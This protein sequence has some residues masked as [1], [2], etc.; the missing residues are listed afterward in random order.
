MN[1][2]DLSHR[3]RKAYFAG[4]H[5][6]RT[7]SETL[8]DY[9]RHMAKMGITRLAV[10]T[11]LDRINV[12]V[13]VAVRPNSRSLAT[14]QGKGDTLEAAKASA[15]LESIEAWHA[16]RCDATIRFDSWYTLNSCGTHAVDPLQLPRRKGAALDP[17]RPIPWI[18]GYDLR[19]G[20][21]TWV[22]YEAVTVNFVFQAGHSPRFVQSSN[23]LA[24]GNRFCE[25]VLHGLCEVVERDAWNLWDLLSAEEKKRRQVDLETV[26]SPALRRTL[27]ALNTAG[28]VAA[29]WDI[30]TDVDVPVYHAIVI[31]N[32]QSP[33]W[34]PIVVSAGCG[35][36][37]DPE[38]ALSRSINEAIQSRLTVIAGSRDDTLPTDYVALSSRLEHEAAI[39][40]VSE[41]PPARPVGHL[42]P[43]VS[44]FFEPDLQTMLDALARVGIANVIVVDL[45]RPDPVI[46]VVKVLVPGLEGPPS[47][48]TAAGRRRR[49]WKS[50][51]SI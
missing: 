30:T 33:Q 4:T 44:E 6:A 20:S 5:R 17:R 9:G 24:S 29:A 3:T 25:A 12:P 16:E 14:S 1:R 15:L 36:H 27:E 37:L 38:I 10:I 22:P 43:Q 2:V 19:S 18:E 45:S 40:I 7:P 50:N 11:G 39:R 47:P 42:R 21:L 49:A 31:E 26:R 23:G 51:S 32:P 34:R 13:V 8:A 28:L 41:P 35:A 46:P 48:F